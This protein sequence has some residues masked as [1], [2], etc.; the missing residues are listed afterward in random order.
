MPGVTHNI[1]LLRDIITEKQFVAG[2]ITT[3]YLNETYPEGFQ[4]KQLTGAQ[5]EDLSAI[6]AAINVRYNLRS[7]NFLNSP[8][9][10][11]LEPENF[12]KEWDFVIFVENREQQAAKVFNKGN[13]FEVHI[14]GRILTMPSNISLAVPI[15][16]I[17][18]N[19]KT[20]KKTSV[21]I[22]SLN[23]GK[24]KL[25]YLGT[26]VSDSFLLFKIK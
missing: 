21:Q 13:D 2:D 3:N 9:E 20:D 15:I 22:L 4:G 14:N 1:P 11:S 24:M 7:R 16:Q 6:A 5:L 26:T 12:G 17:P 8:K 10:A 18:S 19:N 25:Q 23:G